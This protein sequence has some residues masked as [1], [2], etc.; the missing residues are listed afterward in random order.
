MKTY[1]PRNIISSWFNLHF[2]IGPF[3]VSLIQMLVVAIGVGISLAMWN[4]LVKNGSDKLI[5]AILTA[6]IALIFGVIAFFEISELPL[7]PFVAKLIQTYILDEPRKFQIMIHKEDPVHI[8]LK[9]MSKMD[10]DK[11]ITENKTSIDLDKW[12][13]IEKQDIL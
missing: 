1:Y 4:G 9:Q 7:I 10:P 5:A 12:A 2:T 6:P 3:T 11:Q 13:S 8:H